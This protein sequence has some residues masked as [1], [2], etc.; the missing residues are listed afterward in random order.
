MKK[1]IIRIMTIPQS[2]RLIKGQ[3][4]YMSDYYNII[5]VSSSGQEIEEVKERE[6][7]G[8]KVVELTRKITPF[9]DIK[10]L[11]S[12]YIFLKKEKPFI[13]HSHTP[14]AGLIGMLAAFLARVPHR[15]HTVAGMPLMEYNG[16]KRKIL[17]F[18]EKFTYSC[19]TLILPNSFN[20][21][22][23]ILENNYTKN[24]KLKIIANGGS[25]GINLEHFSCEKIEQSFLQEMKNKYNLSDNNFV[26]LY[27]GRIVKDK[28]II[29]L[30]EA[31]KELNKT[32]KNTKLLMVG[33]FETDAYH[34]LSTE[35]KKEIEQHENII[36]CGSQKDVRPFFAIAD[37]FVFPSYRE[38]F[39]NVVLEAGAMELPSIVTDI[40][41]SNEIIENGENGLIVPVKNEKALYEKMEYL[42]LNRGLLKRMKKKC[43]K[44]IVEKYDQKIVWQELL[45]TYNN[46]S[47]NIKVV[48]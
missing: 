34:I 36:Y 12:L 31:F 42:Y 20:L 3:L 7:I 2:F 46:L 17:N 25:N 4:K 32:Y 10:A 15:L 13:V 35:T 14:K 30:I 44:E 43:R 8:I 5:G 47:K 27:V 38:G 24:K 9:K 40:N 45:R 19:A 28:G 26:F 39:P 33:N 18:V 16:I 21:K 1:T 22:K 23:F 48:E 29:E 37:L 41:G 6:N 11:F